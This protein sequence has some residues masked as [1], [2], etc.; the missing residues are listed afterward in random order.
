MM[1]GPDRDELG[2]RMLCAW[3]NVPREKAP[4]EWSQHANAW[5]RDA[6]ARVAEAAIAYHLELEAEA[7]RNVVYDWK[8]VDASNLGGEFAAH[9]G[10]GDE[11]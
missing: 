4:A 10:D 3:N 5:T 7:R 6:W 11:P 9:F 8:Q 1:T 2:L